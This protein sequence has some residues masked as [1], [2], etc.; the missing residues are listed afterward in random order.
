V[1]LCPSASRAS[2]TQHTVTNGGDRPRPE[3]FQHLTVI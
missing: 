1:N 2:G 3:R